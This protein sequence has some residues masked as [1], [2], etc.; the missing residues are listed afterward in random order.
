M[1][2]INCWEPGERGECGDWWCLHGAGCHG[3]DAEM[4]GQAVMLRVA[5]AGHNILI[6]ISAF[7]PLFPMHALPHM[8]IS[9]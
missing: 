6:I 7:I 5:T 8:C 9:Y 1:K 2:T 4:V 3:A